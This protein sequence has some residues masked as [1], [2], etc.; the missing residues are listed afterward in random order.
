MMSCC[1]Q[2]ALH[3]VANDTVTVHTQVVLF[4]SYAAVNIHWIVVLIIS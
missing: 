2:A 3:A 1:L 4:T